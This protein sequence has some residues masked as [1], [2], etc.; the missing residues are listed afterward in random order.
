MTS[1]LEISI[2]SNERQREMLIPTMLELGCIGF[3]ETETA[4]LCYLDKSR[5]DNSKHEA[6]LRELGNILG[7][8]SGNAAITFREFPEENW[9]AE[10]ERSIQPIEIGDR[11]IIKPS[12]HSDRGGDGKLII[13][14]DPKMSFGT[15]YHETTRLTLLLLERYVRSGD[16]ILDVGTGTGI[17]AIAAIK[18]G[19]TAADAT[20]VDDWSIDNATENITANAVPSRICISKRPVELF[21]ERHFDLVAANLTMNTNIELLPQFKRILKRPGTALLSGLLSA[22]RPRMLHALARNQFEVVEE[23]A[24]NEWIALAARIRQ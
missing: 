13:Q 1:Y 17:L 19:A 22:D 14:I 18:L 4:L 2:S 8:I 10:W 9:N 15:G 11:I 16:N 7:N 21:P 20:D 3:Q 5:W 12:W 6:L 23:R 24:E